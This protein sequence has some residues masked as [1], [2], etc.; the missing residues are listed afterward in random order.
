MSSWLAH[1]PHSVK[2]KI[3]YPNFLRKPKEINGDKLADKYWGSDA[4][5][6]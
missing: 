3:V 4:E 6:L 5:M 1:A 2:A